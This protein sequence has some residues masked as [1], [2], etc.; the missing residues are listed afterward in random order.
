[1]ER[2]KRAMKVRAGVPVEGAGR[3]TTGV[4]DASAP[5]R[6]NELR[7]VCPQCR[8]PLDPAH[9]VDRCAGCGFTVSRVGGVISFVASDGEHD[10]RNFWENKASAPDGDTSTGVAYAF[11]I[12][13]RYIVDAFS[14][15][16][17]DVPSS[18]RVLDIGCGNALFWKALLGTR[19]IVGVDYSIGMCCLA[20]NRGMEVYHADAMGLPFADAHFD[21]IYS[22]EVVQ[23]VDDLPAL[24][25]ELGR[26]CRPGGR[27]IVST[28]NRGSLI[29][30]A[31]G[32]YKKIFP[33]HKLPTHSTL[34]MRTAEEMIAA[35]TAANLRIGTICRTHFPFPWEHNSQSSRYLL[36][37]LASNVIVEFLK[38]V[39]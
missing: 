34:V 26:T 6:A 33:P 8:G 29:R 23:Y 3:M 4:V 15:L 16:C 18:A 27:I 21:L 36:E 13:H 28:L 32:V 22:A 24:M 30:R 2:L 31:L 20:R 19:A 7:F 38:P 9:G 37:P 12:Q 39:C 5:S 35:G 10:W 17:G 14:R 11:S 25:R 1:M